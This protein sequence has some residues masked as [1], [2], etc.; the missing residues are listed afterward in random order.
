[1]S[2]GLLETKISVENIVKP[3]SILQEHIRLEKHSNEPDEGSRKL[4]TGPRQ[5]ETGPSQ[6]ETNPK[7]LDPKIC[8]TNINNQAIPG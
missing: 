3:D 1:M 6:C 5:L 7:T 2:P 8:Q 4:E